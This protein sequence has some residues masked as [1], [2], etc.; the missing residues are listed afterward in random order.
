MLRCFDVTEKVLRL[1]DRYF[2]KSLRYLVSLLEGL[3]LELL[4]D[5]RS[6][7]INSSKDLN[8]VSQFLQSHLVKAD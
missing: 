4:A 6:I 5:C 2:D 1:R 8:S 7:L 3:G